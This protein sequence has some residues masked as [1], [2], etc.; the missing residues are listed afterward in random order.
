MLPDAAIARIASKR[1]HESAV[2]LPKE[3][4]L[5]H[6][7]DVAHSKILRRVAGGQSCHETRADL[8]RI[9]IHTH[10]WDAR[11]EH[12]IAET[13]IDAAVTG[14]AIAGDL[15]MKL[16]PPVLPARLQP[17]ALILPGE[18]AHV[19]SGD[20]A[21]SANPQAD[22]SYLYRNSGVAMICVCCRAGQQQRENYGRSQASHSPSCR[23]SSS[24][25]KA[26][27]S[28]G[29]ITVFTWSGPAAAI[30]SKWSASISRML[31]SVSKL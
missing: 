2:L 9:A 5:R 24:V 25:G 3:P 26:L 21:L 14:D 30:S 31:A 7:H 29:G 27:A 19:V 16:N 8:E 20:F 10:K 17:E 28:L 23:R 11:S 18:T 1:R 6:Q 15:R 12:D 4:E 13:K 22:T